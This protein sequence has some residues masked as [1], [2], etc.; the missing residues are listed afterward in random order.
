MRILDR[1]IAKNFLLNF[2]ITLS[3][4]IFVMA[5]ANLFRLVDF[6][7]RGVSGILIL[8]VFLYGMPFFLIFAVPMSVLAASYLLFSRMA[9][10]REIVAMRACGISMWQAIRMPVIVS[11]ILT[12]CCVYINCDIA[13]RSHLARRKVVQT[14]KIDTPLNLLDAGRFIDDFPG[15][16]INI[17]AK[18]GSNL[19]DILI[20]EFSQNGI[21][22]TIRAESGSITVGESNKTINVDLYA[23]QIDQVISHEAG[24]PFKIETT[25]GSHYPLEID[26]ERL[27]RSGTVWKKKAD[28]TMFEI[29]DGLKYGLSRVMNHV[30]PEEESEMKAALLVEANTRMA[31]SVSCFVFVLLG[32]SLGVKIHRRESSIGLALTLILVFIFYFFIMIADALVSHPEMRPYLIVWLP[33]LISTGIGIRLLR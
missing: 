23:V 15:Y 10:D 9:V 31:L 25:T 1:Y 16:K 22:R 8:K 30:L 26:V 28:L 14:V 21:Q 29:L 4:F 7:A 3:V 24:A 32:S 27:M 11:V 6:F 18:D 5:L 20:Y 19:D 33:V 2:S 17:G 12:V 13:P